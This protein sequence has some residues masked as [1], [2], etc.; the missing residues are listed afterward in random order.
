MYCSNCGEK[1]DSDL[2]Y[3]DKCGMELLDKGSKIKD[4]KIVR[5]CKKQIYQRQSWYSHVI[6]FWGY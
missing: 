5:N 1:V 2:K 4:P 3:C 6:A